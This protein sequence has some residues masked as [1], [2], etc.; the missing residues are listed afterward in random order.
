MISEDEKMALK[1]V[2]DVLKKA[3][4]DQYEGHKVLSAY[5]ALL[6]VG[7]FWK[8]KFLKNQEKFIEQLGSTEKVLEEQQ[9]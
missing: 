1:E 3:L 9:C 4:S 7:N 6:S 2:D 5:P 8:D